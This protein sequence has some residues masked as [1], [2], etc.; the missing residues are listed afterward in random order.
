VGVNYKTGPKRKI[1]HYRGRNRVRTVAGRTRLHK[2]PKPPRGAAGSDEAILFAGNILYDP[3]FEIFVQNA[4]PTFLKPGWSAHVGSDSYVLPRFDINRQPTGQ[5]WPNGDTV[6]YFDVAQWSQYTEPYILGS[7]KYKDTYDSSAWF[8]V[9]REVPGET[10][11]Q[12]PLGPNLGVWM[13]RWYGWQTSAN[14]PLGN[15]V[16][17]GLL[18]Q[19]PGMPPG[20]SGRT[21]PGAFIT[22]GVNAWVLPA[23]GSPVMDLGITFYT[24]SG[25][26]VHTVTKANSLTTSKTAYSLSSNTP[27]GSYF[28]RAFATFRGTGT[29]STLLQVDSGIL[30]VE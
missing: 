26:P 2:T 18:I 28:I 20:Y 19:G 14:Y 12:T 13:A 27:G 15:G 8:V 10:D 22:W 25:N 23:S 3:G 7:T 16:P 1:V 21:E 11:W 9:R 29:V 24:Q 5:R 17:G 4:A 6:S 30:G